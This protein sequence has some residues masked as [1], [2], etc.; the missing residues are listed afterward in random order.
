MPRPKR[1]A[2]WTRISRG[3]FTLSMAGMVWALVRLYDYSQVL[4]QL[5][6]KNTFQDF[7]NGTTVDTTWHLTTSAPA[8]QNLL[9]AMGLTAVAFFVGLA[10]GH[11]AHDLE[12]QQAY[13]LPDPV[14][15]EEE[16][17]AS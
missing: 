15:L 16:E 6:A 5:Q 11:I 8:V 17:E 12:I 13:D 1:I 7:A 9:L 3:L 14:V 4:A 2:L 10:F